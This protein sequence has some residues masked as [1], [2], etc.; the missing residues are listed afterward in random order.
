MCLG[1]ATKVTA[2]H[3]KLTLIARTPHV[4]SNQGVRTVPLAKE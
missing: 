3:Y 2:L 1:L 4:S